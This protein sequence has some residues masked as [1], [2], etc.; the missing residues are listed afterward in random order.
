MR[1]LETERLILRD[2]TLEDLN[3]FYE[4]CKVEGVGEMA[5]WPAHT[6]KEVSMQI[7]N[8]FISGGEVYAL[9]LKENNKVIGSLGIHNKSMDPDYPG[10]VHYEIGY[11]LNKEYWGNGLMSEAVKKAITYAFE[12]MM[13]DVLWCGHFVYNDRSRRVV[14]KAGF[15]YYRDG[16]YEARSL[17]KAI[18]EKQYVM[19]KEDYEKNEN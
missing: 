14:E 4:Y 7:L 3:D 6:S 15:K 17:G 5:G 16:I 13:V 11:V 18:P 1:T 8:G 12:E 19:T 9:V 10:D 2:W